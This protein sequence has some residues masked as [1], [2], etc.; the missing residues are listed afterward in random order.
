MSKPAVTAVIGCLSL[1]LTAAAQKPADL[2]QSNVETITVEELR[3]TG[4][5]DL[6]PALALYRP[7]LFS[8][9]NGS[10]LIHNLPAL[11]LLDGRPFASTSH[12]QAMGISPLDLFPLAFLTAVDV[13]KVNSSPVVASDATGGVVDLRLNRNYSGGEAGIFFGKSTGKYGR[14]DFQSYIVGGVGNDKFHITVG[15]AYQESSG[16][17]PRRDR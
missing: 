4:A 11:V 6:D 13:Q 8:T 5:A 17:F 15:A 7:N 14:E 12:L 3:T 9:L 1:C 10:V 16:R 2:E